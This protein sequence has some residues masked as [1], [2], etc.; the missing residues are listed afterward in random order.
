MT[1]PAAP[2]PGVHRATG[3]AAQTLADLRAAGWHAVLVSPG[4][5][6][7]AFHAALASGLA[8]PDWYGANLDALWDS[9][10]ELAGPTAL[11][12][13]DWT[14][15]AAT[16]PDRWRR[17]LRLFAERAQTDPPFAVVLA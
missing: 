7:G 11:V 12:L 3:P 8:L 9:L 5:T 6:A 15:Y 1:D 17:F 16:E 2:E 10:T 4:R 13:T 14:D